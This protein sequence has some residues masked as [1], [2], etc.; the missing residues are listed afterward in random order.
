V[1]SSLVRQRPRLQLDRHRARP[2]TIV[3]ERQVVGCKRCAL[4]RD[5]V[6][7]NIA[8]KLWIWPPSGP[9]AR[10]SRRRPVQSNRGWTCVHSSGHQNRPLGL[11]VGK[12]LEAARRRCVETRSITKVGAGSIVRSILCSLG[13]ACGVRSHRKFLRSFGENRSR[14]GPNSGGAPRFSTVARR[15]RLAA[16][17]AAAL[18]CGR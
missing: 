14:G 4:V 3:V 9:P 2:D 7:S 12:G 17:S 18:D 10:R 16:S 15:S 1:K 5:D 8:S 11:R 6:L 13:P